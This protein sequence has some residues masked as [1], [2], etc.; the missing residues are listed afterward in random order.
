MIRRSYRVIEMKLPPLNGIQREIQ[1]RK[2]P[3]LFVEYHKNIGPRGLV[4]C[5]GDM[6]WVLSLLSPEQKPLTYVLQVLRRL[7]DFC[8]GTA[9]ASECPKGDGERGWH[10]CVRGALFARRKSIMAGQPIPP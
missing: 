1:L 9:L 6:C 5:W 3:E 7:Q 10:W 2:V 8:W 4:F